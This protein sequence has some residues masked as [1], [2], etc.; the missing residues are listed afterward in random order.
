MRDGSEQ[1]DA[2]QTPEAIAIPSS[3]NESSSIAAKRCSDGDWEAGLDVDMPTASNS[4]VQEMG[5]EPNGV[6][7]HEVYR[8][9]VQ[10]RRSGRRFLFARF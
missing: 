2:L 5:A 10:E 3:N 9:T 4:T 7:I 6:L 1:T 8:L